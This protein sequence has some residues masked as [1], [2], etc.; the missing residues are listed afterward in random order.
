M[1]PRRK[2]HPSLVLTAHPRTKM[3]TARPLDNFLSIHQNKR[4]VDGN[5]GQLKMLRGCGVKP[6]LE[7]LEKITLRTKA[8]PAFEN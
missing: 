2:I 1:K 4:G 7:V 8:V 6:T 3:V 5:Q